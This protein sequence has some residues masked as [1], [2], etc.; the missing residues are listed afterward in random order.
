[1]TTSETPLGGAWFRNSPHAADTDHVTGHEYLVFEEPLA[2]I[3]RDPPDILDLLRELRGSPRI[4]GAAVG[5]FEHPHS[6]DTRLRE[7]INTRN[8]Y[9][10]YGAGA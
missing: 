6:S 10:S 8:E 9:E 4:D 3:I 2:E 7:M 1:M 5:V